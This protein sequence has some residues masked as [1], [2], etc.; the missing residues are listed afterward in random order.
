MSRPY[1]ELCEGCQNLVNTTHEEPPEGCPDCASL[2]APELE[3]LDV[4]AAAVYGGPPMS[5]DERFDRIPEYP[6]PGPI[7]STSTDDT[8]L[9]RLLRQGRRVFGAE[10]SDDGES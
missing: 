7:Q 9:D 8:L 2:A 5:F 10:P 4:M 6:A 1:E 3:E